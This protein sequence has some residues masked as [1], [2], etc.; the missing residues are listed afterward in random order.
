MKPSAS[1]NKGNCFERLIHREFSKWCGF[2]IRR[3]SDSG[4]AS[5]RDNTLIPGFPFTVEM[6]HYKAISF[7]NMVYNGFDATSHLTSWMKQALLGRDQKFSK[8][9]LLALVVMREN[10]KPIMCMMLETEYLYL[11]ATIKYKSGMAPAPELPVTVITPTRIKFLT[12]GIAP[13][14]LFFRF[15]DLLKIPYNLVRRDS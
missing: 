5:N 4:S 12:D 6:K 3:N 7:G 11:I 13:A 1:K 14:L 15:D 2:E 9:P 10:G 8:E